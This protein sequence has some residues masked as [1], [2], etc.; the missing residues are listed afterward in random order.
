VK[1]YKDTNIIVMGIPHRYDVSPTSC[2]IFEV[3]KFNR[4]LKKLMKLHPHVTI[5]DISLDRKY[6]TTHG[7]HMKQQ[8]NTK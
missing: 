1:E 4:K 5:L 8:G 3:Q 7:L 6:F 2:V